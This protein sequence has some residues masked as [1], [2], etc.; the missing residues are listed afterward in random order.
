MILPEVG[1]VEGEQRDPTL[2]EAQ[3]HASR[4]LGLGGNEHRENDSDAG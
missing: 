4:N 2:T 1:Q 3:L